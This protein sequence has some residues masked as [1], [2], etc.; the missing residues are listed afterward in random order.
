M[1]NLK[2]ILHLNDYPYT[3]FDESVSNFILSKTI[4][5]KAMTMLNC[6]F[7]KSFMLETILEVSLRVCLY[8]L[9]LQVY[10]NLM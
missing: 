3:F 5:K 1:Q 2:Q 10:V 9:H 6:F 4:L 8:L 7:S